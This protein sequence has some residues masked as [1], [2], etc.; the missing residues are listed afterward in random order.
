LSG[1]WRADNALQVWDFSTGRLIETIDWQ[2][3]LGEEP[4]LLY[5]AQ[6]SKGNSAEYICAGG[7]G[8]NEAKIFHRK[9]KHIVGEIFGFRKGIYAVDWSSDSKMLVVGGSGILQL[10]D[11]HLSE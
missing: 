5:A 8:A 6:F 7:S 4:C 3:A 9:T 1:S 10:F 2:T 11:L